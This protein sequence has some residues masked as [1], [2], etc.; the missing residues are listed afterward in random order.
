MKKLIIMLALVICGGNAFSQTAITAVKQTVNTMFEAMRKGDSTLLRS[1]FA[2]GIV[3]H[4]I[5]NKK[6]GS[7]VLLKED[8]DDFVKSIGTP[9]QVYMMNALLLAI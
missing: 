1:T 4:S 5:A 8:P 9:H 2:K 6:D 7:T 3:F